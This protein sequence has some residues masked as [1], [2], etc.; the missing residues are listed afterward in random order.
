MIAAGIA[1]YG[2]LLTLLNVTG[3]R[4]LVNAVR[5]PDGLRP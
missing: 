4:E 3:W 5:R 1:A 2:T